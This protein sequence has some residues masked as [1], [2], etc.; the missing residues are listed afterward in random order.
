MFVDLLHMLVGE[1]QYAIG[2]TSGK[3]Y[4]GLVGSPLRHEYAVMGPSTNLSARLMG[5][6][7]Q[8]EV[9]CDGETRTRDRTH[10][11]VKLGEIQ[12]KG[13]TNLVPTFKPNISKRNQV[14]L[15]SSN[16]NMNTMNRM[17]TLSGKSTTFFDA[18][19]SFANMTSPSSHRLHHMGTLEGLST[20]SGSQSNLQTPM[21]SR[22]RAN[23]FKR[24]STHVNADP[25]QQLP[26]EGRNEEIDDVFQFLC[27]GFVASYGPVTAFAKAKGGS[28]TSP[29]PSPSNG[30]NMKI[31]FD[32]T[33]RTKA[34][35]VQGPSGIGKS[36]FVKIFCE[37]IRSIFKADKTANLFVFHNQSNSN[38]SQPFY[39]WKGIIRQVLLQFAQLSDPPASKSTHLIS[40]LSASDLTS[41]KQDLI[42]GLDYATQLMAPD[43]HDVKPLMSSIHFVY[44]IK[45][46]DTT[47]KLSGIY[48]LLKITEFL[49]AILQQFTTSTGKLLVIAM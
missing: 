18:G 14:R 9:M 47:S 4:C 3:A 37:K 39:V 20:S 28:G 10:T 34:T 22:N 13:Y 17:E 19:N 2:I 36:S 46:N 15:G 44:G 16:L 26:L 33:G 42:K 7:K 5:K 40:K 32:I 12:A 29:T 30:S 48:K 1:T 25:N 38:N 11:F 35:I 24:K 6:A 31:R 43:L 8:G 41:G 23:R 21:G 45:E 49:S 27:P